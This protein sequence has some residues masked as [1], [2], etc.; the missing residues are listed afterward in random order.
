M[1]QRRMRKHSGRFREEAPVGSVCPLHYKP[2]KRRRRANGRG[3]IKG[4][5]RSDPFPDC[6]AVRHW[7]GRTDGDTERFRRDDAGPAA[8]KT[9]KQSQGSALLVGMVRVELT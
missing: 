8:D 2:S 5:G 7:G 6:D 4:R 9:K 1:A 3:R